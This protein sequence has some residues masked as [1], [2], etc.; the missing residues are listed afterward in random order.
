M[1]SAVR[2]RSAFSALQTL[3]YLRKVRKYLREMRKRPVA[4]IDALLPAVRKGVISLTIGSPDRWWYLSELANA[5]GTSPSSLQR[6]L[7]SLSRSGILEV[8]GDGRRTYYRAN[9]SSAIFEELRGI[10]RKTMGIPLEI[11][12]ALTTLESRIEAAFIYGSVARGEER[13]DSDVDLFVV[14][15]DLTLEELYRHLARVER[16]LHRKV[17][18][19]LYSA[20]E[21]H[22]KRSSGNAFVNKVLAR[23]RIDLIGDVNAISS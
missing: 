1:R 13:A 4:V 8:R 23:E 22:R 6:E 5:L 9:Q 18:P 16:K 19:T 10:V 3:V 12:T 17:N 20:Q 15:D 7:A 14:A 21:F 11:R 2:R